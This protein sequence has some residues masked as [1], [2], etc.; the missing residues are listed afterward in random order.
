MIGRDDTSGAFSALYADDRGVS[1]LHEM[2]F[3]DGLWKLWRAA[4]GFHQRFEGRIAIDG[5]TIEA[6]WEK[7]EDGSNWDIDFRLDYVKAES[8][9]LAAG[10]TSAL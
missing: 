1:R 3:A 10:R 4:P 5:R 6:K 9:S 2:S 7:S 8:T